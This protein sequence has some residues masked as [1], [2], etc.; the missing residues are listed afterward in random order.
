MSDFIKEHV[1]E[2]KYQLGKD[3]ALNC[4]KKSGCN[5]LLCEIN[6]PRIVLIEIVGNNF[7]VLKNNMLF[8]NKNINYFFRNKISLFSDLVYCKNR[9]SFLSQLYW[10][11]FSSCFTDKEIFLSAETVQKE[12]LG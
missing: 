6:P 1:A 4:A 2:R 7:T 11:I 5:V 9:Q 3:D 8:L 12:K 10:C